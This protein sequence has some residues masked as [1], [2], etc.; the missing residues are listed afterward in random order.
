M[1]VGKENMPKSYTKMINLLA[2]HEAI[3]AIYYKCQL[4]LKGSL[5]V[6][7]FR[8]LIQ[9]VRRILYFE[10]TCCTKITRLPPVY[11]YYSIY[12]SSS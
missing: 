5:V 4:L 2:L 11:N 1:K 12:C 6:T 8:H 9:N 3:Q 7:C 10:D